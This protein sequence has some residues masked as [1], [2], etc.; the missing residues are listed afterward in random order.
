V[1]VAEPEQYAAVVADVRLGDGVTG[2][3]KSGQGA[4]H[5]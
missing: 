2:A 1:F 3:D 5:E 4:V